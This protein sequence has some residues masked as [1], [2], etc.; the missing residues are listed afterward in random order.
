MSNNSCSTSSKENSCCSSLNDNQQ[1]N[2]S[3]H[4]NNA[5]TNNASDKLGW[6][7]TDLNPTLKLIDKTEL[8]KSARIINIGAGETTLIDE[9][10]KQKYNNLVA[11]D[12]SSVALNKLDSRVQSGAVNYIVDDITHPTKLNLITNVDLWI[13]RAVLHFFID[14]KDQN[15]YFNLLKSKV[16]PGGFVLLA[17]FNTNGAEKCSGLPVLRYNTEMLKSRLG[18]DFELIES[19]DHI[20]T[21]PSGAER[22]YIY[23]LFKRK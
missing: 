19:F 14:E 3:T 23:T 22:P 17:Q 12:I 2:L 4:W 1:L 6:F 18:D 20:Y 8:N 15:T 13:D 5:Y 9:L 21:M 11:T 10:L 7:E 16:N